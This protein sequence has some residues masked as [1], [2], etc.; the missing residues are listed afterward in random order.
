VL[1]MAAALLMGGGLKGLAL[2]NVTGIV[3]TEVTRAVVAYR[4]CP[5]LELRWQY[6]NRAQ[7]LE[8]FRFGMKVALGSLSLLLVYQTTS[9]L[10]VKYLGAGALA[11]FARALALVRHCSV[12]VDKF[13][14][15]LTPTASS[16]QAG[17]QREELQT[18]MVQSAQY[19]MAMALP[20][21]L[22]L[23]I[24]GETIL[25]LWMG[26]GYAHGEVLAVLA[27]GHLM[28]IAQSPLWT[29]LRGINKHGRPAAMRLAFAVVCVILNWLVLSGSQP[30]LVGTALAVTI[31]LTIADGIFLPWYATR[32][33]GVSWLHYLRHAW[34]RPLLSILPFAIVLLAV[35]HLFAEQP[36]AALL[37][38][39]LLGGIS[40]CVT[41]WYWVF[42]Q[43]A[44]DKVRQKL[45]GLHRSALRPLR[46][47]NG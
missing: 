10:I 4:V 13:A 1:M 16:M 34:G 21:I 47:P 28:G 31:P 8:I 32:Q 44:R 25:R 18:F 43:A 23:V 33:F 39:M 2:A 17:G 42:P 45:H 36:I 38:S 3:L 5:E 41:Y 14:S 29:I 26:A 6:C 12:F 22:F 30:T 37:W 24:L 7:A 27:L 19:S 15:I 40:L 20:P 46:V 11:V 9:L 35:D